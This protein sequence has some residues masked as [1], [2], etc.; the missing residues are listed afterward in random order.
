MS[1]APIAAWSFEDFQVERRARQ[2]F[3]LALAVEYRLLGRAQRRGSGRTRNISSS[4]VLF[5]V[6]DLQPFSGPIELMVTWPCLLD[7]E[8]A[9]KLVVRGRVV[10]N[11]SGG[12]A[13]ESTQ[14]EFRTAGSATGRKRANPQ[15]NSTKT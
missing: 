4:G 8:C 15:L 3:P 9:L 1:V 11:E 12:V 5:E 10:R 6:S 13:I 14:H 7:D 2:R